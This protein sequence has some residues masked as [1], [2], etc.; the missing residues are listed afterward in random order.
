MERNKPKDIALVQRLLAL[1]KAHFTLADLERILGQ[2]RPVLYVTLHRLVRDQV[3]VRLRRGVYQAAF[4]AQA[5]PRVANLLVYPSYLSFESA[6]AQHGILSQLPYSLSFATWRRSRRLTLGETV[7]FF[8]QLKRSLFFGYTLADGMY[9]AEPEK[10]VLDTCYLA[11]RGLAS[12]ALDELNLASLDA[13][14]LRTYA[15]HFPVGVQRRIQQ[16][17][18]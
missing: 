11:A 9:L 12:L 13:D 15:A 6:L 3:L 16:L 8:H 5:L 17:L 2:P 10:A 1:N 7:V 14:R 4:Q 18:P